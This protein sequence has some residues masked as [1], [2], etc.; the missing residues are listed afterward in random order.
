MSS[1]TI[2]LQLFSARKDPAWNLSVSEE[3]KIISL[4]NSLETFKSFE[5]FV[6]ALG[7][8][9][10][11]VN[12]SDSNLLVFRQYV[13]LMRKGKP[14][15]YRLDPDRQLEKF[16]IEKTKTEISQDIID[17]INVGG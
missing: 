9:G 11:E 8:K 10:F 16:L 14:F 13:R 1:C 17:Y 4:W 6:P 3:E 12:C 7:Y 2:T 5:Q 15:E